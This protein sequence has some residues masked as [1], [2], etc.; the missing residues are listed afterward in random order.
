MDQPWAGAAAA[1]RGEYW[2]TSALDD[3]THPRTERPFDHDRVARMD[4]GQHLG[5]ERG[6][7]LRI[8]APALRGKGIH[9]ARMSGPLQNTRSIPFAVTG[10]GEVRC[11]SAPLRPELQHV[12]EH[13]DAAAARTVPACPSSASAA[14]IDAGLAL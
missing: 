12:A 9:K 11:R 14:R 3:R 10:V 8:A 7:S 13:R 1:S 2:R 6:R 4:G 5:F